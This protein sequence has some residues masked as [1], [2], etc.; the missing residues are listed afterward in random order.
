MIC[1][2]GLSIGSEVVQALLPNGRD[3]DLFD[4]IANVV[5][6]TLALLLCSWYH[7][8]MLERK[9]ASKNYHIVPGDELDPERDVELGEGA[10]ESGVVRMDEDA[11]AGAKPT[12]SEELDNWDE[13]AEDWDAP[14]GEESGSGEGQ[15]TPASSADE[16]ADMKKSKD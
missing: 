14:E 6:S 5:G 3:F 10:Q 12:V 2:A 9:R 1:T 13:N 15:K 7:K 16:S 8:R 4:I 11:T